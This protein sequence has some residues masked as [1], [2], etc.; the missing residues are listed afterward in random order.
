MNQILLQ[1]LMSRLGGGPSP[2]ISALLGQMTGADGQAPTTQ[3]M[4]SRLLGIAGAGAGSIPPNVED[5]GPL[6][7]VAPMPPS[8]SSPRARRLLAEVQELR[9][10][11]DALASALGACPLCWGVETA[12]RVCRGR[13]GPGFST[14]DRELFNELVVPAVR[15]VKAQTI[16]GSSPPRRV[17]SEAAETGRDAGQKIN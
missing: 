16:N 10:R 17:K 3:E 8:S 9:L 11:C 5:H 1:I 15:M 2:D 13:G 4:L 7:E 12:C 6:L 14:P